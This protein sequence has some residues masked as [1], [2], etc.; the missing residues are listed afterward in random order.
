MGFLK[1]QRIGWSVT[2]VNWPP[3]ESRKI[4]SDLRSY[5]TMAHLAGLGMGRT[6]SRDIGLEYGNLYL[7]P[8]CPGVCSSAG[9]RK[10]MP[11]VFRRIMSKTISR[12][13]LDTTSLSYF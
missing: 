9:I 6:L 10:H 2:T 5:M 4:N 7:S 12:V 13:Y 8:E 3:G 1:A 11:N